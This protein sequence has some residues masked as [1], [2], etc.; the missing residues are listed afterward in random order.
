MYAVCDLCNSFALPL[1]SVMLQEQAHLLNISASLMGTG[2]NASTVAHIFPGIFPG[3]AKGTLLWVVADRV[4]ST[5][6]DTD[7]GKLQ[8]LLQS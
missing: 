3:R 2:S 1:V 8:T 6:K 7:A 4:P 5:V